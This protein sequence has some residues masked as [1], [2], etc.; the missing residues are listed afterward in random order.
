LGEILSSLVRD[1]PPPLPVERFRL[2][3][4]STPWQQRASSVA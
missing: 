4:F 2:A 1:T 3:R